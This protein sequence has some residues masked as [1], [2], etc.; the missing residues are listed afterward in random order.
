MFFECSLP[1]QGLVAS[2][3]SELSKFLVYKLMAFQGGG[4]V[5]VL[6]AEGALVCPVVVDGVHV[7]CPLGR[8]VKHH[9]TI[10]AIKKSPSLGTSHRL[11]GSYAYWNL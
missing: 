2:L 1:L 3:T 10:N 4:V 5:K 7:V 11:I 8:C 6:V 9:V